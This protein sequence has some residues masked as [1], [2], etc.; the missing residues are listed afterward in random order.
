MGG[1]KYHSDKEICRDYLE[2]LLKEQSPLITSKNDFEFKYLD[3]DEDETIKQ[4]NSN[5]GLVM[6]F[7]K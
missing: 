6:D 3:E 4:I 1:T 7:T 5:L 2:P